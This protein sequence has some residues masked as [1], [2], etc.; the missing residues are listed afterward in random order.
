MAVIVCSLKDGEVT[1]HK[2]SSRTVSH[3]VDRH[4]KPL[5]LTA[6][7]NN[8][9]IYIYTIVAVSE[10]SSDTILDNSRK[11][12]V[13]ANGKNRMPADIIGSQMKILWAG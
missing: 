2:H 7:S 10:T 9:Y 13:S 5:L 8:I 4:T 11:T 6:S 12:H 3:T 1:Q